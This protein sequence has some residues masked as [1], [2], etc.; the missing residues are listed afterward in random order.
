[1]E[2]NV[3]YK[4]VG[5]FVLVLTAA[6]VL[7]I[8][9]LSSGFSFEQYSTY[10]VYMQE[11]VS[12]LTP[13]SP[14]EYNGVTVGNV[15]SISLNTK[16]PQLVELA[17]NIQRDI[18][19]TR[20]TTATLNT[21]GITGITYIALKDKSDDLRPLVK[22]PGQK[23]PVIKTAPSLFVR[24]D[25]A[26]SQFIKDFRQ[27]S[28]S[29]QKIFDEQNQQSLKQ[30]LLNLQTVTGTLANNNHKLDLILTNTEIA[31][32]QLTPFIR[33]SIAT[34]KVLET[35]TLP[36]TYRLISNLDEISQSMSQVAN[37]L[38]QN[39]SV[40]IRG[41]TQSTLGPGERK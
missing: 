6:L 35:Q 11:S 9:W 41:T 18:P 21:R 22:L 31:S 28:A 3:N 20:G 17:L 16:N 26:L 37:D 24:L 19:I 25:T 36:A 39:P 2:T 10:M 4:L 7:A 8:I 32:K 33:S 5:A 12:G 14:V 34:M 1:M 38:K 27:V 30:I 15:K 40:L 13:D 29:F 23:Y